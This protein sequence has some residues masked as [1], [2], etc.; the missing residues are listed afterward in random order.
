MSLSPGTKLGPYEI[1]ALLG[2]GGM[3]EVYRANVKR[4]D[5]MVAIKV[6]PSHLS[7]DRDRIPR[8]AGCAANPEGRDPR[9]V[10]VYVTGAVA[11]PRRRWAERHLCLWRG[12]V[13]NGDRQ[14]GFRRQ[15]A[16]KRR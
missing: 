7:S 14:T 13:R 4:L 15:I 1:Q 5:R 10:S 3:G 2:A 12:A 6:L 11:R 9:H 16:V 8:L